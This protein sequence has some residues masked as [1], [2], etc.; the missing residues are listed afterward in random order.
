M[1]LKKKTKRFKKWKW[2][3]SIWCLWKRRKRINWFDRRGQREKGFNKWKW[4]KTS[5]IHERGEK[6][7]IHTSTYKGAIDEKE[8]KNEII[9]NNSNKGTNEP[10]ME[11][12]IYEDISLEKEKAKLETEKMKLWKKIIILIPFLNL[13]K[14]LLR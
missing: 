8:I 12:E 4:K 14:K 5:D 10:I 9:D 7:L 13:R 11:N 6:E 2:R 1:L 3:T